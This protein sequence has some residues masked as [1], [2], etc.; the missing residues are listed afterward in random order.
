MC[1]LRPETPRL[2]RRDSWTNWTMGDQRLDGK[3]QVGGDRRPDGT[4][5]KSCVCHFIFISF[6]SHLSIIIW[7]G[8]CTISGFRG[9]CVIEEKRKKNV[10]I[11]GFRLRRKR[12]QSECGTRMPWL[13]M[14]CICFPCDD[15]PKLLERSA[16]EPVVCATTQCKMSPLVT[17][18]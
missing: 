3:H 13:L 4:V 5:A 18:K 10:S 17:Q 12:F 14:T 1:F 9:K 11:N 2:R 7:L 6:F 16:L 15:L 8:E